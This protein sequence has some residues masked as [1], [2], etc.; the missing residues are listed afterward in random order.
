MIF[1]LS[2]LSPT[3]SRCNSATTPRQPAVLV[4]AVPQLTRCTDARGISKG[5][6]MN[7]V[8]HRRAARSLLLL[9]HQ[10]RGVEIAKARPA[11]PTERMDADHVFPRESKK[12]QGS[13][14]NTVDACSTCNSR[15][16][17]LDPLDCRHH[18]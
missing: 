2:A 4:P 5:E 6:G 7:A 18:A 14:L 12:H 17:H 9:R 15:K 10:T 3:S 8:A 1:A 16:G 11:L 13:T